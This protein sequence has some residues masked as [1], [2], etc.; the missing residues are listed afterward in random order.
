MAEWFGFALRVRVG[1]A[2]GRVPT[3][4]QVTIV[5][6]MIRLAVIPCY[7]PLLATPVAAAN[8]PRA[9][10]PRTRPA[11]APRW[12]LRAV[13]PTIR[14]MADP[15]PLP[16]PLPLPLLTV[17]NPA[18]A[19]DALRGIADL[20]N[21]AAHSAVV[22]RDRCAT[23]RERVLGIGCEGLLVRIARAKGGGSG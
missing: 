7:A 23:D 3:H 11:N 22:D 4:T 16:L 15:I 19:E 14:P 5:L 9:R 17:W 12:R 2:T 10:A 18:Y 20:R 21:P 13:R 8:A 6:G 1:E